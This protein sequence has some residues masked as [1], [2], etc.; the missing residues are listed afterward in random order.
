[1][2][3]TRKKYSNGQKRGGGPSAKAKMSR[4]PKDYHRVAVAF[5]GGELA[6]QAWIDGGRKGY[7]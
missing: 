3:R 5:H 7:K 4:N 2:S 1:M 6:Y